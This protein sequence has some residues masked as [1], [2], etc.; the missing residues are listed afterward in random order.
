[1]ASAR[2]WR[3][4]QWPNDP[5]VAHLI[6]IDHQTRARRRTRSSPAVDHAA[7][8]GAGAIRTSAM[9]PA[10][11]DV[12]ISGRV[13]ARSTGSPCSRLDSP[14]DDTIVG[15]DT[16]GHRDPTDARLAPP[17]R[18]RRRPAGVRAD[19]GQRRRRACATSARATPVHHARIGPG[20]T[21]G[22][23]GFAMSG[24]AADSGYLQRIA[25]AP[26]HR[27]R[28][29]ARDLVVDALRW[30]H[31][32]TAHGAWSTPASTTMRR[33]RSTRGSASNACPTCSR[34]PN[35]RCMRMTRR[36]PAAGVGGRCA[37]SA[38]SPA[39]VG[40]VRAGRRSQAPAPD[41]S[42]WPRRSPSSPGRHRPIRVPA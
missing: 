7:A 17:P 41:S 6:F 22:S 18:R 1:M 23:A 36:S 33:W 16:T 31:T 2:S 37:A 14:D 35:G 15:F 38:T 3:M 34:S 39:S 13:H 5:T 25:V 30:M 27:R 9:F 24:A 8:K 28:G 42:S 26:D 12:V 32:R 29:I 11:A 4:R 20:R 21:V 19:V 40:L 10:S